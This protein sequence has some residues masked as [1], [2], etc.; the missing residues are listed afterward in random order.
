M[1]ERLFAKGFVRSMAIVGLCLIL[2]GGCTTSSQNGSAGTASSTADSSPPGGH[3]LSIEA[4]VGKQVLVA[5][6]HPIE[7]AGDHVVVTIDYSIPESSESGSD[8]YIGLVAAESNAVDVRSTLRLV[9]LPGGRVWQAGWAGSKTTTTQDLPTSLHRGETATAVTFFGEVDVES[10]DVLIPLMGLVPDVPVVEGGAGTPDLASLGVHGSAVYSQPFGMESLMQ[11][12]DGAASAKKQ[13]D[14]QTVV[15]AS[16]VLFGSDVAE[17]SAEAAGRVDEVAA[18]IAE[19]ASGGDVHVVGH[20]DDVDSEEYN[21]DL[22]KRRAG[23]VAE[24]MRSTL[25]SSFSVTEDG[26]GESEPAVEGTNSEARAAN[27]R[28]EIEF[29]APMAV[30]LPGQAAELPV[31]TGPVGNEHDS[32]T[33]TV[34]DME[35]S[36]AVPSVVRRNG[37]LIGT[38]TVSSDADQMANSYFLCDQNNHSGQPYVGG[39]YEPGSARCVTLMGRQGRIFPA[40]YWSASGSDK[41]RVDV[42]TDRYLLFSLE[43]ESFSYT[44]IWPDTGEDSVTVDS[45]NR[46]RITGIPVEEG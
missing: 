25:G 46:F 18:Q 11:A 9:D 44:V 14:A 24:R 27:R 42:L 32:V 23:A 38:I 6:V 40:Q 15:M 16:D 28:V 31:A 21:L 17:L 45:P 41:P 20:T 19:V 5:T 36:V 43:N 2:V 26:R 10:V 12:Y 7:R 4:V 3:D 8:L 30:E 13:G 34:Y 37:Y 1:D 33:Y 22:S 35:Y 39:T 29:T